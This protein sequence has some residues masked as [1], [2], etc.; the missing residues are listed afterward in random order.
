M[1]AG[2]YRHEETTSMLRIFHLDR[3]HTVD[4][5]ENLERPLLRI[6]LDNGHPNPIAHQLMAVSLKKYLE[7]KVLK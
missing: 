5:S 7:Q 2:I 6:S 1:L 3:L 4:I